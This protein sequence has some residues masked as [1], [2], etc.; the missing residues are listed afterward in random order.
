[1]VDT[2]AILDTVS[3]RDPAAGIA[4]KE[5]VDENVGSQ[6]CVSNSNKIDADKGNKEEEEEESFGCVC[7]QTLADYSSYVQHTSVC[8]K[9]KLTPYKTCEICKKAF[10]SNCGYI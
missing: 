10:F 4:E 3:Q 5:T 7:G 1:M 8:A 9:A 6:T 2:T